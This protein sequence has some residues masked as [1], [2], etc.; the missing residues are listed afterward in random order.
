[1]LSSVGSIWNGL[2]PVGWPFWTLRYPPRMALMAI[3]APRSL[4]KYMV[5][6]F[7]PPFRYF[8]DMARRKFMRTVFPDPEVPMT[9]V[10][11]SVFLSKA[12]SLTADWWKLK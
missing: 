10:L 8:C 11:A 9:V 3:S 2:K 4:S 5:V 1:M 12:S 7:F 6:I